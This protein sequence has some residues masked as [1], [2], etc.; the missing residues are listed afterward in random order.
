[1]GTFLLPWRRGRG[2][3]SLVDGAEEEHG[4]PWGDSVPALGA[5]ALRLKTSFTTIALAAAG[6]TAAGTYGTLAVC[7]APCQA[8]YGL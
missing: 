1:M 8:L 7:Q 5:S 4:E 2:A 3:Q 6:R